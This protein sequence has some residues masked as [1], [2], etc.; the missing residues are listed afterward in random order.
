MIPTT[1]FIAAALISSIDGVLGDFDGSR[2]AWYSSDAA[3]KFE[4]ALPIGNGRLGAM[5]F[6]GNTEK[7]VLNE[8]SMWSGPWQ[9]RV[10]KNARGAAEDIWKKLQ[11]GSIT[12]AGQSA[13]SN[14]AGDPT[15]PRAYQPLVNLVADFGHSS[16]GTNYTRWLDTYEGTTGVS[17][18]L[19]GVNYTREYVA[20]FPQ[21]VLAFRFSSSMPGKL[22][23]KLSLSREKS[24]T[25]QT[26]N[27]ARSGSSVASV[28][29][30]NANSGQ[31]SGAINFWSEARI[32]NAGGKYLQ[33]IHCSS[34]CN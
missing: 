34:L 27:A 21:G 23:V 14:L 25:A 22:G 17:Y 28:M 26:A 13:M 18:T 15:S 16:L 30:L 9:D 3:N 33:R 31:S 24:V 8:N 32:V 19:N 2:F 20:S 4:N 12:A 6:G 10:N 1:L 11:A 7:V 5:V 29:T